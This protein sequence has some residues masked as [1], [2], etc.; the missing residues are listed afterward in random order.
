M[1]LSSSPCQRFPQFW[2][3]SSN[4][5]FRVM[6]FI[7]LSVISQYVNTHILDVDV[8]QDASTFT[9][10]LP[11]LPKHADFCQQLQPKVDICLLRE[12]C[13]FQEE[14]LRQEKAICNIASSSGWLYVSISARIFLHFILQVNRVHS[15]ACTHALLWLAPLIPVII[16]LLC[17]SWCMW[18][19]YIAT[20]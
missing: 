6:Q 15:N 12:L 5:I 17:A 20:F 9:L 8:S 4:G 3:Q 18:T 16:W 14:S 19:F 13:C 7:D 1:S 11:P 10:Q 2:M